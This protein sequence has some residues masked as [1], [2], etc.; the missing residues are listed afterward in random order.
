MTDVV[1]TRDIV[2]VTNGKEIGAA[3]Q[4]NPVDADAYV[5]M[6][7]WG[8][9][10]AFMKTL[11]EKFEE[12]FEKDVPE[13]PLKSEYLLPVLIDDLLKEEK[14]TVQV[15][16]TQDKWFGVTYAED[17]AFVVESIKELI[18][19]GIYKEELFSDL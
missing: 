16:P 18:K 9:T 12:F 14:I 10:P 2:K 7:M 3:V 11:G 4:G 6:N 8:L 1:E 15:L 17:R 19:K 13:N 5:S